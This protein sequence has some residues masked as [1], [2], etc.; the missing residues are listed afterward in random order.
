M[1]VIIYASRC[2]VSNQREIQNLV[3]TADFTRSSLF[4]AGI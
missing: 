3:I 4:I 1:Y 2:A